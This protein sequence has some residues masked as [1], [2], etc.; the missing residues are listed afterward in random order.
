MYTPV[1]A[2]RQ[3]TIQRHHR[4]YY[5]NQLLQVVTIENLT[6]DTH[7]AHPSTLTEVFLERFSAE[8]LPESK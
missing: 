7:V 6:F 1:C 8:R 5:F 4:D 2:S 3:D